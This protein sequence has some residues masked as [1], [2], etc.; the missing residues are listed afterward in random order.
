MQ[1][2]LFDQ[3]GVHIGQFEATNIL[4]KREHESF[5]ILEFVTQY[6]DLEKN[7]RVVLQDPQLIW[8]EFI[9]DSYTDSESGI[10]VYCEN[11]FY[12]TFGDY[13]TEREPTGTPDYCLDQALLN[14]RWTR[15]KSLGYSVEAQK[16]NFYRCSVREAV[17]VLAEAFNVIVKTSV[18]I[19]GTTIIAR[20]V[21]LESPSG[22]NKG[23]R[24]ISG[25]NAANV[26][27]T[28]E[29]QE[30][31]TC[32]YGYGASEYYEETGGY[33][34]RIDFSSINDGKAYVEDLDA[35]VKYGRQIF[36]KIEFDDIET[37]E[38]LLVATQK[39]LEARLVP[40]VSYS[41]DVSDILPGDSVTPG[42]RVLLIDDSLG[43]RVEGQVLKIDEYLDRSKENKITVGNYKLEHP[44]VSQSRVIS[45]LRNK[46]ATDPTG[47]ALEATIGKQ[48]D[49]L[50]SHWDEQMNA[51]LE[52]GKITPMPG[53]FIFE[54]DT[55]AT[56]IG[57]AGMRIAN[58]KNPDGTWNFST[59]ANGNG[60]GSDTVGADQILA[61]SIK[62][63]HISLDGISS[64]KVSVDYQTLDEKLDELEADGVGS[65]R[66]MNVLANSYTGPGFED[67]ELGEGLR[68]G[69]SAKVRG[70]GK[71][72]IYQN[73]GDKTNLYS[74]EYDTI[75]KGLNPNLVAGV[76]N[77]LTLTP[78]EVPNRYLVVDVQEIPAGS[79][80]SFSYNIETVGPTY[81]QQRII[82]YSSSGSLNLN[83]QPFIVDGRVE[84]TEIVPLG[85]SITKLY[86]YAGLL[87]Q[88]SGRGFTLNNLVIRAGNASY[89]WTPSLSDPIGDN[90]WE[91][92]VTGSKEVVGKNYTKNYKDATYGYYA[93]SGASMSS[94]DIDMSDEWGVPWAKKVN[95]SGGTVT[96]KGVWET[97]NT[98]YLSMEFNKT[99]TAST[100][101]KNVGT[102][103]F[104]IVLNGLS[105][106]GSSMIV[107]RIP[108]G[109]SGRMSWTGTRR[110]LYDWFQFVF[111]TLT[112]DGIIDAVI[113]EIKIE[114]SNVATI[115][116]PAHEDINGDTRFEII[117]TAEI[118][119][120]EMYFYY[121]P[122]I[123]HE[124]ITQ[125]ST[126]ISNLGVVIQ[127]KTTMDGVPIS[128]KIT[129]IQAGMLNFVSKE[130]VNELRRNGSNLLVGTTNE[131]TNLEF[132]GKMTLGIIDNIDVFIAGEE[133]M[134]S[135]YIRHSGVPS[136]Q[137][138]MRW[139]YTDN[140]SRIYRSEIPSYSDG[141]TTRIF[142]GCTV[143]Y[144]EFEY[145]EIFLT[146]SDLTL[147]VE[148][149]INSTM[150]QFGDIPTAW[151]PHILDINQEVTTTKAQIGVIE[152]ALVTKVEQSDY[153]YG[154]ADLIDQIAGKAPADELETLSELQLSMLQTQDQW[155]L[156]VSDIQDRTGEMG[157][158]IQDVINYM[159]FGSTGLTLGKRS[160]SLKIRIDNERISFLD[161]ESEVA[162]ITGQTLY[163][164]SGVFLKS[165]QIGNHS[166]EKWGTSNKYTVWKPVS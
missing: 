74:V 139:R 83:M 6:K 110:E 16:L 135:T 142:V 99:Y 126:D 42:E 72:N 22:E 161:G 59:L 158:T 48:V 31:I 57:P 62:T 1:V 108:V 46:L 151:R 137:L 11:A 73:A 82:A 149:T 117:G 113:A 17:A 68:L 37:R 166:I 47:G 118:Q 150:V 67:M 146:P 88:N 162:Y 41:G 144:K 89:E 140:G 93:Y 61:G 164:T 36:G 157:V 58:S 129:D 44:E 119:Y 141:E 4:R 34:R 51:G 14:T 29:S 50:L 9:I 163:I 23:Y 39:E 103:D 33:S 134:A 120:A 101:V 12:E 98:S 153:E 10:S 104:E 27:R 84:H 130:Q 115:P 75:N 86:I 143:P 19:S 71:I 85:S 25:K 92:V 64:R 102:T 97:R 128:E 43:I 30:V 90:Y 49:L 21:W 148:A 80:F 152:G 160:S 65:L 136:V 26:Q 122:Y 66:S 56:Q 125:N 69:A 35:T 28:V 5:D 127:E 87:N 78:Q 20:N 24:Y 15:N 100:W 54:T 159:S 145:L 131:S 95:I 13:I 63:D 114:E 155:A 106:N 156:V 124:E 107:S 55:Q 132:T 40:K 77:N 45:A 154:F 53:G 105:S 76:T 70:K 7:Y 79:S 165:A 138:E 2:I 133:I 91:T 121:T 123:L 18:D 147:P 60:L 109:Y 81:D 94:E 96:T 3:K 52:T 38:E 32:L 111:R 8:H 116:T 112:V